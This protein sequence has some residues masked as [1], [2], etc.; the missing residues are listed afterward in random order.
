MI[1]ND[2]FVG[3]LLEDA[4]KGQP[5]GLGLQNLDWILNKFEQPVQIPLQ[6]LIF[7]S[8]SWLEI[9]RWIQRVG[10]EVI[11]P[12][13]IRGQSTCGWVKISSPKVEAR[14]VDIWGPCIFTLVTSSH[15]QGLMGHFTSIFPFISSPPGAW[16]NPVIPI[17]FQWW[18]E[19]SVAKTDVEMLEASDERCAPIRCLWFS[20]VLA[21]DPTYIIIYP[22]IS[23]TYIYIIHHIY[24]YVLVG[25]FKQKSS[26]KWDDAPIDCQKKAPVCF[27]EH[28]HCCSKSILKNHSYDMR[29]PKC[30]S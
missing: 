11:Q 19:P 9:R 4:S 3:R 21:E 8:V 16:N 25:A 14:T 13:A 28:N 27:A 6:D 18:Q 17:P 29:I 10:L 2:G 22:N 23:Y 15:S 5:E 20:N 24:I 30:A 12:H 26:S 1:Q 7:V